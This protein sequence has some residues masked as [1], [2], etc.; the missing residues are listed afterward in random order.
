M[1]VPPDSTK[2]NVTTYA[3]KAHAEL[4]GGSFIATYATNADLATVPN[5]LDVYFPR[6]V[7]VP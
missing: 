5:D 6:F 3:G 4:L 2:P 1:F 7:R